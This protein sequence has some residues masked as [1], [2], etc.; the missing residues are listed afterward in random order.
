MEIFS[1]LINVITAFLSVYMILISLRIM[2][3][4]FGG[5]RLGN[6]GVMLG[7]ITDPYLNIFRRLKFL[8]TAQGM[9]F[10]PIAALLVLNLV[11]TGLNYFRMGATGG[12]MAALPFELIWSALA[13][14]IGLVFVVALVRFITLVA[15]WGGMHPVFQM[16]DRL[17]QPLVVK[18]SRM[19]SR[20]LVTY[21]TGL[22]LLMAATVLASVLGGI[23]L[24]FIKLL[25]RMLLG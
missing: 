12:Q 10:S 14:F 13:F 2:L 9:D 25:L 24:Y 3:T 6:A 1:I 16:I 8:Q 4:W 15:G 17:I 5:M 19:I 7:R 11:V 23:L 20:R 22:L 21:R 18:F